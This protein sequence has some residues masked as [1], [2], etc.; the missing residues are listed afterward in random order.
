[1]RLSELSRSSNHCSVWIWLGRD[2]FRISMLP[3]QAIH[4]VTPRYR[5]SSRTGHL[6][7]L[8]RGAPWPHHLHEQASTPPQ[9]RRPYSYRARS[10]RWMGIRTPSSCCSSST[11]ST[12]SSPPDALGPSMSGS[13]GLTLLKSF[14][15]SPEAARAKAY[16]SH[17]RVSK[18]APGIR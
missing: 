1:M 7:P 16:Q 3:T 12:R 2:R 4:A 17:N 9:S 15:M 14:G 13:E 10:L 8:K 5:N 18:H 6:P 11:L